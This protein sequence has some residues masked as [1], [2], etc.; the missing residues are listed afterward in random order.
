MKLPNILLTGTP[1]VGKTT[2]GKELA[3]RSGLKYVNVGDLAR[4]GQLYDGYDEEYGCPILDEDRVVD[5]LEQQMQ[6]GGVIVDYHGC[7]FFPERWFHIVFVLRTDNGILYKRLETRGYNEKKLQDNIQCE[8]FQVL[9][10]EAIASYKEEI[11]HQLPSNEP[12]Q[13]EDNINQISKWIEQ[14]VKDHNP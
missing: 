1:G 9:Y 12:E 2:L 14:W 10:E 7:D 13:L 6:E 8:I 11:V 5:E 4:E 3:S